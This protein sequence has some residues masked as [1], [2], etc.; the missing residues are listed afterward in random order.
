MS[1]T[2]VSTIVIIIC[3]DLTYAYT[4]TPETFNQSSL[5]INDTLRYTRTDGLKMKYDAAIFVDTAPGIFWFGGA[6][7]TPESPPNIT[8]ELLSPAPLVGTY[9]YPKYLRSSRPIGPST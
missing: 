7:V 9:P 3:N 2:E 6:K 4:V 5:M 8:C 1:G